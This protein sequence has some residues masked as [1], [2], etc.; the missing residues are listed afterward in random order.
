MM[1][2][3]ASG[4]AFPAQQRRGVVYAS[5]EKDDVV[6]TRRSPAPVSDR[7]VPK[8]RDAAEIGTAR[9]EAAPLIHALEPG[10]IRAT[11][12][13]NDTDKQVEAQRTRYFRRL[14]TLPPAPVNLPLIPAP[15]L[16]YMDAAR[17]ILFGLSQVYNALKQH[18]S[19]SKN[20][21]LVAQLQRVLNLAG[22]SMNLLI[23]ALDRLDA[24]MQRGVPEPSV[25]RGVMEASHKC[26]RTFQTTVSMLPSQI[27]QLDE[28][29]DVRFSRTLLLM[30]YGSMAELRNS[31]AVM[32]PHIDAVKP[33]LAQEAA[34]T[35][36]LHAL[37][38][39]EGTPAETSVSSR[40]MPSPTHPP[41]DRRR[42]PG[43][44]SHGLA[45]SVSL[46]SLRVRTTNGT[47]RERRMDE[48]LHTLL[49]Q[50][51]QS[52]MHVW[53]ELHAHIQ[54]I[55]PDALGIDEATRRRLR[56]VDEACETTLVQTNRLQT[57]IAHAPDTSQRTVPPPE[58][59]NVWEE[60][61]HFV[62]VRFRTHTDH[63]PHLYPDQGG[64][65]ALRLPTP[66]HARGRRPEPGLCRARR[67]APCQ[68]R[69]IVT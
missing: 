40:T 59:Y 49:K 41:P 51:T 43:A 62:R 16:K 67:P 26:L 15:V 11:S 36:P 38:F 7:V 2:G 23:G 22:I 58:T 46:P 12:D 25:I 32:A 37:S 18:I 33:Y 34:P 60:A 65:T 8:R 17:G 50:V 56:D 42:L 27:P 10:Q 1:P 31:A 20:E 35:T 63:H 29:V 68:R 53:T 54:A 57:A 14:S 24:A 61:N 64:R 28:S 55:P 44:P 47:Q 5:R 9:T 13:A 21:R 4:S 48:S 30:L 45:P 66:S 19:V 52:A 6:K 69:S 3:V 39:G